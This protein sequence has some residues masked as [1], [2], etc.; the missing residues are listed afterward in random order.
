MLPPATED[1]QHV[2]SE[3]LGLDHTLNWSDDC[4]RAADDAQEVAV[5]V[6]GG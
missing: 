2:G 4:V 1:L 6:F 5:E 3:N